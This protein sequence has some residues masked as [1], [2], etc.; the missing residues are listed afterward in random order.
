LPAFLGIH[1][2]ANKVFEGY[3]AFTL[4]VSP[5]FCLSIFPVSTTPPKWMNQYCWNYTSVTDIKGDNIKEIII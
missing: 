4:F 5:L 2:L 1:T 3:I